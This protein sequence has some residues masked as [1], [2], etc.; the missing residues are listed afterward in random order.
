M[1]FAGPF[2]IVVTPLPIEI[3]CQPPFVERD[4]VLGEDTEL[5]FRL[6]RLD[7]LEMIMSM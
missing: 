6:F 3:G 2:C 1:P 4:V 5:E 7:G